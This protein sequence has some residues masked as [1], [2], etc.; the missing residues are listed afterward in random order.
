MIGITCVDYLSF[1]G[2]YCVYGFGACCDVHLLV[3]VLLVFR[4]LPFLVLFRMLLVLLLF[5]LLLV[6]V[7]VLVQVF[8]YY[9]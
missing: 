3:L 5:L 2:V 7:L 6:L 9:H 1:Y 8:Q 4:M